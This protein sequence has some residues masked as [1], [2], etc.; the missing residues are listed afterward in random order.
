MGLETLTQIGELLRNVFGNVRGVGAAMVLT[1]LGILIALGIGLGIYYFI[2]LIKILPNMSVKDFIK[3]LALS[4]TLL[5]VI[6]IF[7]P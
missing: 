7:I 6:G 1:G 4:A 3:F 2:K 5:I